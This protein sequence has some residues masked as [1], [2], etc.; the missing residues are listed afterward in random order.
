EHQNKEQEKHKNRAEIDEDEDHRQDLRAQENEQG[1]RVDEGEN[2]EQHRMYGIPRRNDH[3]GGG[4]AHAGK[5]VEKQR[6]EDHS[7]ASP[8]R[9]IERDVV[10]DLALPAVAVREQAL[11]VEVKLL[12]RLGGELEVPPFDDGV[13]RAGFLA[14]PAVDA[15][16]HTD[17]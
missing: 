15:F 17:V 2:E 3:D 4:D 16:D 5:Q 9:R 7:T 14:K 6:G 11:L 13:D 10:G 8:V 1:R 12:A